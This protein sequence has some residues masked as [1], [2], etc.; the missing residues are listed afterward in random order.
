MFKL[1]TKVIGKTKN[2]FS[3][4]PLIKVSILVFHTLLCMNQY[5]ESLKNFR[6]HMLRCN[7]QFFHCSALQIPSSMVNFTNILS[8]AFTPKNIRI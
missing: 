7:F 2:Y 6:L 3:K 8:A 1:S 5:K 4:K